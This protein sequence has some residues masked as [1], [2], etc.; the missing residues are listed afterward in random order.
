M[1]NNST[2]TNNPPATL[3]NTT[4]TQNISNTQA[5]SALFSVLLT[6]EG[7][8]TSACVLKTFR[9][10]SEKVIISLLV[11]KLIK[12]KLKG[13]ML[14]ALPRNVQATTNKIKASLH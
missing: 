9:G 5:G 1:D 4:D 13:E 3:F 10:D 8:K 7:L 2:I 14:R 6:K 12:F 11:Y